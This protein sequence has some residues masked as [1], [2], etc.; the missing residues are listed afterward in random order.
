L[1]RIGPLS[2][3]AV[4][5]GV[6]DSQNR[7]VVCVARSALE[8]ICACL[9]GLHG[10]TCDHPGEHSMPTTYHLTPVIT[11]S[12]LAWHT[13][14]LPRAFYSHIFILLLCGNSDPFEAFAPHHHTVV[15]Q[16][17]AQRPHPGATAILRLQCL[18]QHLS[19]KCRSSPTI[20]LT[21]LVSFDTV[22][23]VFVLRIIFM[24]LL[25]FSF[26]WNSTSG[27]SH[28]SCAIMRYCVVPGR[29]PILWWER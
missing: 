24:L 11:L 20:S 14:D 27:R 2:R 16:T 25:P 23:R 4:Q 7:V 18:H 28:H 17:L 5:T 21:H 29:S 13:C 8:F 10:G 6:S 15:V 1:D 22:R 3:S 12:R 19:L 26:G 9:H